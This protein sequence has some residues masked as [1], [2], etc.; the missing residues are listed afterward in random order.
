MLWKDKG[1][2]PARAPLNNFDMLIVFSYTD[3]EY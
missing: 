3:L 1:Y 2:D